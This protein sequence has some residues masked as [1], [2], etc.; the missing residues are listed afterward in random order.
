[1]SKI[2]KKDKQEDMR[3]FFEYC[4]GRSGD[5]SQLELLS[6]DPVSPHPARI[7]HKRRHTLASTFRRPG[8]VKL[9]LVS[10]V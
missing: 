5:G 10:S 2:E 8:D 9:Q 1:M 4:V 3:R 6:E 7:C